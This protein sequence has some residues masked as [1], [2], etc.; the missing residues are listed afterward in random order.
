MVSG[1]PS[2]HR[3]PCLCALSACAN[4]VDAHVFSRS[5]HLKESPGGHLRLVEIRTSWAYAEPSSV[6]RFRNR[7]ADVQ[8]SVSKHSLK[9]QLPKLGRHLIRS[10]VFWLIFWTDLAYDE[11]GLAEG[12]ANSM[13]FKRTHGQTA[14][15][16]RIAAVLG[17]GAAAL[18][19]GV[20]VAM[21]NPDR[22]SINGPDVA[23]A[24]YTQP[25][26][27]RGSTVTWE[28]PTTTTPPAVPATE[29][30]VPKVKAPH[31]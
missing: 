6:D 10:A 18:M 16:K 12:G 26:P 19:V 25:V 30:A 27:R 20:P 3:R 29:K 31:R 4:L 8:R 2:R 24:G 11:R 14:R 9:G 23:S 5:I 7:D 22:A 17:A 13:R 28:P 21:N 15:A 1:Y